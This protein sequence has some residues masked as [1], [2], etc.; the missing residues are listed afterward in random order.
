MKK[1]LKFALL[2][3]VAALGVAMPNDAQAIPAWARK[4]NV[5]CERCHY[6]TVPRLS[7]YGEQF[8]AAGFR[9]LSEIGKAPDYK[10]IGNY[11]SARLRPHFVA[12]HVEKLVGPSDK[13]TTNHNEF[14][15]NDVTL[16]YSGP[17][18]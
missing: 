12:T 15:F 9:A 2:A 16:F 17:I 11:L 7:S 5:G 18:T 4:Y 1:T 14:Q 13:V 3:V 6:P 10:E 8:R